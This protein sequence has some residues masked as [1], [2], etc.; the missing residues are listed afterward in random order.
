MEIPR[1]MIIIPPSNRKNACDYSPRD[2][3]WLNLP[4]EFLEANKA[5]N[6][7][8]P[9]SCSGRST[10]YTLNFCKMLTFESLIFF[11]KENNPPAKKEKLYK[12]RCVMVYE[13]TKQKD[14]LRDCAILV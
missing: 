1:E 12:Y 9:W 8:L 2:L 4:E 3:L 14:L 6:R 5:M 11:Y 7:L 10:I 13:D